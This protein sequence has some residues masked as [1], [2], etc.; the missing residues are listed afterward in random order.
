MPVMLGLGLHITLERQVPPQ[1]RQLARERRVLRERLPQPRRRLRAA[2]RIDLGLQF[3]RNR[4]TACGC[5]PQ[6]RQSTRVPRHLIG[7]GPCLA[8][9]C[10]ISPRAHASAT[11]PPAS[12][13]PF[14]CA[15]PWA[16]ASARAVCSGREGGR[17][18][19]GRTS[20]CQL[21]EMDISGIACGVPPTTNRG[22]EAGPRTSMRPRS[23]ANA[24]ASSAGA[25]AAAPCAAASSAPSPST[26]WQSCTTTV[27]ALS[28]RCCSARAS[29]SAA[30]AAASPRRRSS[31][32]RRSIAA[33]ARAAH[34]LSQDATS[35]LASSSQAA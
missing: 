13:A 24:R 28:A 15:T 17:G 30:P 27:S 6:P 32:S 12:P 9:D 29:P 25:P 22:G 2:V 7:L 3:A 26:R 5:L 33:C 18:A 35:F 14:T 34:S 20:H 16:C 10:R 21:A 4:R 31:A 11:P 23:A 8:P 1:L 19:R